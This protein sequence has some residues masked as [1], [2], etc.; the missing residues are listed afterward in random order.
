ML[1]RPNRQLRASVA[2][3]LS[4]RPCLIQRCSSLWT[5]LSYGFDVTTGVQSD[6]ADGELELATY[7]TLG[8]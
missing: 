7:S 1:K 6:L 2:Q 4:N 8:P 3:S 5:V